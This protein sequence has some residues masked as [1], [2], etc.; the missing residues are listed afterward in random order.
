MK[1]EDHYKSERKKFSRYIKAIEHCLVNNEVNNE[2]KI[3]LRTSKLT[4]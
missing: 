2:S 3:P 4:E 1:R